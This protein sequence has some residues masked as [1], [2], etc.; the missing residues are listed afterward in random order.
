[1]SQELPA[2]TVVLLN[3]LDDT[4]AEQVS[5]AMSTAILAR[6]G[7]GESV[8][9]TLPELQ[10]NA[11]IANNIVFAN[12]EMKPWKIAAATR[13]TFGEKA[14]VFGGLGFVIGWC[15][16]LTMFMAPIGIVLAV[17]GGIGMIAGAVS[18]RL[19]RMRRDHAR[20]LTLA[21]RR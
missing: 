5:G 11:A 16:I 7:D 18:G 17:A 13:G 14:V 20:P 8:P 6:P 1:M 19:S 12:V 9:I 21:P 4:L 2:T 15:M 3:N 10:S